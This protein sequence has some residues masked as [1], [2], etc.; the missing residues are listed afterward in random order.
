MSTSTPVALTSTRPG[1]A[2][3]VLRMAALAAVGTGLGGCALWNSIFGD[4]P[5]PAEPTPAAQ[6]QPVVPET[7][8]PAPPPTPEPA[9]PAQVYTPATPAVEIPPPSPLPKVA[10]PVAPAKT[11]AVPTGP[12]FYINVGL[13]AV[14]TNG[15][16]A[17]GILRGAGL[18]V[19]A[20]TVESATKGSLTRVRVGPYAKRTEAVAAAKKIK[21]LKLDAMVFERK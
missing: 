20:D 11:L 9:A 1:V 18:P 8:P 19:F 6:T 10:E 3:R 7:T 14:P 13:F 4:A 16:N 17:V 5:P 12:G 21:G 15:S 2:V